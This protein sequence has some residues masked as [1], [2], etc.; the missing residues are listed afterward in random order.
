LPKT[1]HLVP[2]LSCMTTGSAPTTCENV[3]SVPSCRRRSNATTKFCE[4]LPATTIAVPLRTSLMVPTLSV[5]VEPLH[6]TF[7]VSSMSPTCED[8]RGR[9]RNR[10]QAEDRCCKES[11]PVLLL[12]VESCVRPKEFAAQGWLCWATCLWKFPDYA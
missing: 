1:S 12:P 4:R 9:H 7:V 2:S 10:L 6:G 8:L 3:S 11:V 5:R